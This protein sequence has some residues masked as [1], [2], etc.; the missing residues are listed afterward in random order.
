MRVAVVLGNRIN[1][2]G[3]TTDLMRY[4]LELTLELNEKYNPDKIILSGGYANKNVNV[5]EASVMYDYLIGKGLPSD[6]LIK[7]EQSLATKQNA[8]YSAQIIKDL[9]ADSVILCSSREHIK[10]IY[11][12]PV[13]LFKK[14]LKGTGINIEIFTN[15][16]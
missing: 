10:R 14:Q 8:Y 13:R 7:E 1:D 15:K 4:R 16:K 3:T 5:S 12:N 9:K 11:L 2:D 6:L